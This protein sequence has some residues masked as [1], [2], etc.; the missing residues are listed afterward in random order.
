M[1][2]VHLYRR[3]A[4]HFDRQKV[5]IG[6]FHS[7]NPSPTLCQAKGGSNDARTRNLVDTE[8]SAVPESSQDR[9]AVNPNL[10]TDSVQ[11][12]N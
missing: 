5:T 1:L 8:R 7:V 2:D 12:V 3:I 6:R 10:T 11:L 4:S 9:A